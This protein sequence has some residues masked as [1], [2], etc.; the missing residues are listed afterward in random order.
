[1][2][3]C[4]NRVDTPLDHSCPAWRWYPTMHASRRG[5]VR[6]GTSL[7]WW[8]SWSFFLNQVVLGN[9]KGHWNQWGKKCSKESPASLARK[10]SGHLHN[11]LHSL[12]K[13][14]PNSPVKP[15]MYPKKERPSK[16]TT[17]WI[18]WNRITQEEKRM[19]FWKGHMKKIK[20]EKR[21]GTTCCS[22]SLADSMICF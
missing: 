8:A 22:T 19:P 4:E 11:H 9:G 13:K 5:G 18:S 21:S 2:K 16:T 6:I 14:S 15:Q 10:L 17:L 1:M 20:L 12:Q 3:T 7:P